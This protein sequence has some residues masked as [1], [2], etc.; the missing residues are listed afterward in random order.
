MAAAR[1][2]RRELGTVAERRTSAGKDTGAGARGGRE[3]V[4]GS[5]AA[6]LVRAGGG[7]RVGAPASRSLVE[8]PSWDEIRSRRAFCKIGLELS[9]CQL[10]LDG[11]SILDYQTEICSLNVLKD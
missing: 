6:E 4:G 2:Y 11:G 7:A 1:Q 8:G 3:A 5:S 9:P 10:I